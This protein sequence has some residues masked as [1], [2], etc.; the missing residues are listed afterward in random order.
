MNGYETVDHRGVAGG[1][2]AA[3]R[4]RTV[5]IAG[6]AAANILKGDVEQIA[7]NDL[8]D[9]D[10]EQ[11]VLIDLRNPGELTQEGTVL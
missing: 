8:P 3:A 9:L 11:D 5:N 1:V 2:T 7:W 4:R 6:F 10:C